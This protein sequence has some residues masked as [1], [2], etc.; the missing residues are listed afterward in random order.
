AHNEPMM[1]NIPVVWDRKKMGDFNYF[2]NKRKILDLWT[3]KI[4]QSSGGDNIYTLGMRGVGDTKM[5]GTS[6]IG[7]QV[8]L[9]SRIIIDQR[10]II[11]K[12]SKRDVSKVAQAFL[13]YKEVL[14]I[15]DHGLKVTNDV[16]LIWPDNNYGYIRRQS[17]KK[18]R[19]RSGSAGVYYHISYWGRPH[20]YLWLSSTQPGLSRAE[21]KK[22][23]NHGTREKWIINVRDIKTAA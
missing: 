16:T 14:P 3:K 8:K 23:R 9:M 21:G 15:H 22:T 17:D 5:E 11:K 6:S 19:Q 12:Y 10:G 7:Q 18:E 20:D 4:K 2:T 13:R 1:T